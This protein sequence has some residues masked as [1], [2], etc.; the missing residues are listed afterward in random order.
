MPG[1]TAAL[2]TEGHSEYIMDVASGFLTIA[3][4]GD[5]P[6][7]QSPAAPPQ[8]TVMSQVGMSPGAIVGIVVPI[9]AVILLIGGGAY[10]YKRR[11]DKRVPMAT[12]QPQQLGGGS[13]VGGQLLVQP[14][15]LPE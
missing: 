11:R 14:P 3:A 1:G 15:D 4:F 9:V 7:V 12:V 13:A 5:P 8:V 6:P 2:V 10:W